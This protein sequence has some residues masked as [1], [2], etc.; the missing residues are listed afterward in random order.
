MNLFRIVLK[1]TN[2][3]KYESSPLR[4]ALTI[5]LFVFLL[6]YVISCLWGH[7]GKETTLL[8]IQD[9]EWIDTMYEVRL[10]G[11]WG[12]K[13]MNMQ[14][15]LIW[16]LK[17]VMPCDEE[18]GMAIKYEE[19]ALKAQAV[20][21]R[22]QLW[23]NYRKGD[24]NENTLTLQD[25]A[26]FHYGENRYSRET[27]TLYKNAV[28]KTDGV[29]LSYGKEPIKAAYFPVSN[30]RTR[31]ASEIM[32]GESYPY[33]VSVECGQ[34]I[35]AKDYQSR[36]SMEKE[37]YCSLV[38]TLFSIEDTNEEVWGRLE[39]T[40]DSA[41]YVKEASV[42]G[43]ACSGEIFRSAL[44]LASSSFYVEWGERE[45]VFFVKGVGHGLGMSQYDANERAVSG[46]TFDEILANY[47]FQAELVKIE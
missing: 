15:Y 13:R 42:N 18:D 34:D 10:F 19:E 32:Y 45:V 23:E 41:E 12:S 14:E 24:G 6:P 27:E 22:T 44:G 26:F 47:F 7:V 5:L 3:R 31:N 20:L 33:L 25:D 11:E 21:L 37:K 35:L 4:D 28:C 30:G 46:E 39:L 40:Y 43:H 9:E 36:V 8:F 29:Y 38:G 17:L 1:R 2:K 16:K